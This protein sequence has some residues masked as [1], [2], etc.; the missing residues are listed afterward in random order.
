MR[1]VCNPDIGEFQNNYYKI[2]DCASEMEFLLTEKYGQSSFKDIKTTFG[3]GSEFGVENKA[4]VTKKKWSTEEK[5]IN[6]YYY[7]CSGECGTA[8]NKLLGYRKLS[9]SYTP[10]A[11]IFKV[12]SDVFNSAKDKI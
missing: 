7:S 2:S 5:L 1:F 4:I 12:D 9:I 10:N 3:K 8:K 6:Y 11:N